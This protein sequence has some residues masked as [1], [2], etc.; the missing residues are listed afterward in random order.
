MKISGILLEL[1]LTGQ[2]GFGT[3]VLQQPATG[4]YLTVW[5]AVVSPTSSEHYDI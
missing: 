4:H 2:D 3:S 1:N 5:V